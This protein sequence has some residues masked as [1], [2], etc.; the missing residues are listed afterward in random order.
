MVVHRN[1]EHLG[2]F[3][4]DPGV[5]KHLLRLFVIVHQQPEDAE[6]FGV[7][8]RQRTDIYVVFRQQPAHV[9]QRAR[10]VLDKQ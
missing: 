7:G 3:D 4:H 1:G 8:Q 9:V 5:G 2:D 10:M 6:L